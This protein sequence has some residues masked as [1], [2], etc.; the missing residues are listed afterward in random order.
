[1]YFTLMNQLNITAKR[2]KITHASTFW[3]NVN[4]LT[5]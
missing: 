5:Y 2:H 3:N 4:T 1:M